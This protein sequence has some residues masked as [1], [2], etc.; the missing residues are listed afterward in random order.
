M[1]YGLKCVGFLGYLFVSNPFELFIA[2]IILGIGTA[3]GI[4]AYDSLYSKWL[5]RGKYASEWALW[6]AMDYIISA[7][8]AI[9]GGILVYL[10]GFQIL[11]VGMFIFSLF[12]LSISLYVLRK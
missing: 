1:G 9:T 8:A 6:E 11:F 12:G 5:D 7:I 4:P 10:Y 2:Q 3:I